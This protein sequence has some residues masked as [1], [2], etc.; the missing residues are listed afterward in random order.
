MDFKN[1]ISVTHKTIGRMG[2]SMRKHWI[3]SY[4]SSTADLTLEPKE[5]EHI[6]EH[7]LIFPCTV[8]MWKEGMIEETGQERSK[9]VA[10]THKQLQMFSCGINNCLLYHKFYYTSFLVHPCS[11]LTRLPLWGGRTQKHL[12]GKMLL[13][14]I[15]KDGEDE[16]L[17]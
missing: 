13:Y 6:Q 4:S 8:G 14:R 7:V 17:S 9:R 12:L 1:I 16:F 11:V 5:F 3:C 10:I 2:F 15:Q